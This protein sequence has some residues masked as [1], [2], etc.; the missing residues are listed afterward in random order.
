MYVC[1]MVNGYCVFRYFR[2]HCHV[3][4]VCVCVVVCVYVGVCVWLCVHGSVAVYVCA[5]VF[6]YF[7]LFGIMVT[8]S[9]IFRLPYV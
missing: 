4:V 9:C 3:V 2:S 5:C 1:G 8:I 6:V 7:F